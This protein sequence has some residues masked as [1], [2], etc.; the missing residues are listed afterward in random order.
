MRTASSSLTTRAD[1]AQGYF[2]RHQCKGLSS[3]I[4]LLEKKPSFRVATLGAEAVTERT[5]GI[6]V[7]IRD[8]F[9]RRFSGSRAAGE[10]AVCGW[11][12]RGLGPGSV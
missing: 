9:V 10:I 6:V 4:L 3:R 12:V 11:A 5:P 8:H 2:Y 7:F 1:S